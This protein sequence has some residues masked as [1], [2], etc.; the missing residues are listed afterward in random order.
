MAVRV[1]HKALFHRRLSIRHSLLRFYKIIKFF[2]KRNTYPT[3]G[4]YDRT[5]FMWLLLE[6]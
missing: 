3:G 2:K 5:V 4:S 6:F 1:C